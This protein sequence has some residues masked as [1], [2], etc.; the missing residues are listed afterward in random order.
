MAKFR[1]GGREYTAPPDFLE[2]ALRPDYPNEID[3]IRKSNAEAKAHNSYDIETIRKVKEDYESYVKP[4]PIVKIW[5]RKVR[6]VRIYRLDQIQNTNDYDES[7][8][9]PYEIVKIQRRNIR[10]E[11]LTDSMEHD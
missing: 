6:S 1:K 8:I 2:P 7:W 10:E 9:L 11:I 3:K 5:R 4:L